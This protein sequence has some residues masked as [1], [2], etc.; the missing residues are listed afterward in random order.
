MKKS[1]LYAKTDQAMNHSWSIIGSAIA[2]ATV[3]FLA[4]AK[5]EAHVDARFESTNAHIQALTVEVLNTRIHD[6]NARIDDTNARIDRLEVR[7]DD[8]FEQVDRRFDQII[9]RLGEIV[10][11]LAKH[12]IIVSA[13]TDLGSPQRAGPK[14]DQARLVESEASVA[15]R[16]RGQGPALGKP[17]QTEITNPRRP[18]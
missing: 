15:G 11:G 7:M 8:Q 12:G 4:N 10:Q 16:L 6:A 13:P 17:G 1:A 3:I 18:H 14:P 2:L 5:T 9:N